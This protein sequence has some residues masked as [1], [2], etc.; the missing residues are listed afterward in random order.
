M[1]TT[2]AWDNTLTYPNPPYF[3]H[4]YLDSNPLVLIRLVT[5]Y[6]NP[7]RLC[8]QRVDYLWGFGEVHIHLALH[9]ARSSI[10]FLPFFHLSLIIPMHAR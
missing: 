7:L 6:C 1:I 2:F 4:L 5:S 9:E 3:L 8:R 10:H